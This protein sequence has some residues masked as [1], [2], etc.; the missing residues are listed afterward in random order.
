VH[1]VGEVLLPVHLCVVALPSATLETLRSVESHPMALKQC[2]R[3]LATHPRLVARPA[4][5]TAGAARAVARSGDRTRAAIASRHAA[6][7]N[8]LSILVDGAQDHARN[9]TR[10]VVLGR[11]KGI[12][13]VDAHA[14]TMLVVTTSEREGGLARPVEILAA[15]GLTLARLQVRPSGQPWRARLLMEIAHRVADPSIRRAIRDLRA[16]AQTCRSAGTWV[17]SVT[18]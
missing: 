6:S 14:R 10:F 18:R 17:D 1:I 15:H 7:L 9:T 11:R 12:L 5:D 13:R 4:S 2:R 16:G 3:F 8:G